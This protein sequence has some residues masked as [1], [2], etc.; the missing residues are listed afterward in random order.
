MILLYF[1]GPDEELPRKLEC[2]KFIIHAPSDYFKTRN[3]PYPQVFQSVD[4]FQPGFIWTR[5]GLGY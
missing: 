1:S 5:L 2:M 4:K 3:T